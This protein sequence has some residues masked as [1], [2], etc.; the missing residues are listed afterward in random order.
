MPRY[1]L[2]T[3]LV[4]STLLSLYFGVARIAPL[5]AV[6]IAGFGL[7]IAMQAGTLLL[8]SVDSLSTR[9]HRTVVLATA[10]LGL[11]AAAFLLADALL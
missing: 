4:A 8:L 10:I 3:L 5:L 9:L 6:L 7:V 1:S 11:A 2:M